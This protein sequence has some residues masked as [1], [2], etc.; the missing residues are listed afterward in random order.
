[1]IFIGYLFLIGGLAWAATRAE[2]GWL[3]NL[4]A[5]KQ[6][7]VRF[8]SMG[9]A[10]L[11]AVGG[12][13]GLMNA[14]QDEDSFGHAVV[15]V[16]VF[17]AMTAGAI[18]LSIGLGFWRGREALW[19]RRV[20]WLVLC[21]SLAVPSSLTLLLPFA[22]VPVLTLELIAGPTGRVREGNASPKPAR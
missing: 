20:G 19:L 3:A 10:A 8:T 22:V 18:L 12:L 6:G 16:V 9:V 13:A 17:G 5:G 7:S 2:E 15:P 21:G 4:G 11:F 14:I 1:M